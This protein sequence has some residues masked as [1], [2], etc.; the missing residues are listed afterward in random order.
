MSSSIS[1]TNVPSTT[2]G[3][4]D[5]ELLATLFDL[6]REVTS[7]L[8]L[9]ELLAKIPQLIGRVT[10]FSVFSVY[11]VDERRGDLKIAYAVGYPDELVQNFRLQ[12]GQGLVGTAVAEQRPILVGDVNSDPRYVSVVAGIQSNL[13]VPLRHKRP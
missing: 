11:L 5:A 12:I 7:V 4:V 1:G 13:A 9:H 3:G 8:D 2:A 6:G 10:P